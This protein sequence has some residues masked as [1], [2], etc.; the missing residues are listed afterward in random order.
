MIFLDTGFFFALK[1]K[2]DPNHSKAIKFLEEISEKKFGSQ[3]T[4][5]YIIDEL[6]TLTWIRTKNK[7]LISEIW[8]FFVPPTKICNIIQISTDDLLEIY[9]RFYKLL[10]EN[11]FLSFTDCSILFLMEK[12]N[13]KYLATFDSNFDGLAIH[14]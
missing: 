10:D 8:E 7:N 13:I 2:K 3:F 12:Y 4:S 11:K 1:F 14:I 5:D 9:T 6:M